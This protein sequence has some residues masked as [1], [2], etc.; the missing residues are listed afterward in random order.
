MKLHSIGTVLSEQQAYAL[1]FVAHC[2]AL[3]YLFGIHRLM[4]RIE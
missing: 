4:T 1:V 3:L 2:S